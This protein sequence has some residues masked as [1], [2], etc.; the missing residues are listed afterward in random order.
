MNDLPARRSVPIR[1]C[2]ICGRKSEK[3]VL[4]R[5]VASPEGRVE[6]DPYGKMNGR[7]S[8]IC[9]EGCAGNKRLLRGR[10]EHALRV[11][12]ADADWEKIVSRLGAEDE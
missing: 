7:G 12:V 4:V 8:Y 11:T 6:L 1:T 9:S 3:R 10:L 2:V 5:I